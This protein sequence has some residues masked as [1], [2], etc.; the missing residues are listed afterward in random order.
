[1]HAQLK[2]GFNLGNVLSSND[3][4]PRHLNAFR[5]SRAGYFHDI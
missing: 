5:P 2:S 4:P 1:L 3:A